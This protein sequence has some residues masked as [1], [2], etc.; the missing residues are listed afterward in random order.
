MMIF[1][2]ITKHLQ[3]AL[4][5]GRV[6]ATRL[7]F[8]IVAS[9][10]CSVVAQSGD[11]LSDIRIIN[12]QPVL[13]TEVPWQVALVVSGEPDD[14]Y[15]QVCGGS[16][17]SA[18][19]VVTAAHCVPDVT[20]ADIEVLAGV[21]ILGESG[22]TRVAVEEIIPHPQYNDVTE[23]NDIALIKLANPLDLSGAEKA[24]I[25]LPFT[26]QASSWPAAG[27]PATVSGWGNTSTTSAAYPTDLMATVVDVLTDPSETQCGSYLTTAYL[28]DQMLCAAQI[29]LGKDSCQ[30]DSGGPLAVEVSGT[31]T[32]A[33]IVSWGYGCAD[34]SYP[35]V[36][37]R[38]TSYLNW[39]T[40]EAPDLEPDSEEDIGVGL[41]IWLL[42]E[43]IK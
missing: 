11:D 43:A 15:A 38:V 42:Y 32:L 26:Q 1:F 28:P 18:D 27:D 36:Y 9:L 7:A 33:G 35:G 2:S 10:S 6:R 31:W 3:P 41:P 40:S 25:S 24:P 21:T 20:A 30:G 23:E 37:T 29:S 39:I 5:L 14:F 22:S 19:W 16:I 17:V 34:P 13:I 4:Y 8:L 12:G